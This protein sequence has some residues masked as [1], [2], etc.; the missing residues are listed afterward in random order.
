MLQREHQERLYRSAGVVRIPMPSISEYEAQLFGAV[1]AS[2]Q[3]NGYIR[4]V[5]TRGIGDLGIDP[6]L[7]QGPKLIILVS[8]ISL[9][10][11][12]LYEEG[13]RLVIAK[14]RKPPREVLNCTDAKHGNYLNNKLAKLEANDA[15]AHEALM[16]TI[17]GYVCEASVENVFFVREGRLY[18]P[19]TETNCL[20]GIT[21]GKIIELATE[22]GLG[23]TEGLFKP[24][25]LQSAQEVFLTGTGAGIL[26]VSRIDD[27][28]IG[29]GAIG[30][31]TRRLRQLYEE[32]LRSFCS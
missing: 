14:T 9:F 18:T 15:G 22:L 29:T 10:P 3:K 1:R 12:R 28:V 17:D 16:L 31:C 25:F 32:R 11:E 5:R 6:A 2:G 26:P 23:V 8:T 27:A 19:S 7:C 13:I 24:D 20:R 4:I 30:D 21:R